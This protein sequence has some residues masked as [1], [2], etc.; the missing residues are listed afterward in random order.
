MQY[1]SS[2]EQEEP[3]IDV[4]GLDINEHVTP[5]E[6]ACGVE[7]GNSGIQSQ[8][9]TNSNQQEP[10]VVTNQPHEVK[11]EIDLPCDNTN[12]PPIHRHFGLKA[13]PLKEIKPNSRGFK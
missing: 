9:S 8:P 7:L 13:A 10:T 4:V 1:C 2:E 3:E 12:P 6:G 11:D 5:G